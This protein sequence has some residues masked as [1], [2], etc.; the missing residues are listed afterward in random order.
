MGARQSKRSVDIS[1]GATKA[2]KVAAG[3]PLENGTITTASADE[4][5]VVEANGGVE[6]TTK[7][8]GSTPHIDEKE[9]AETE[10]VKETVTTEEEKTEVVAL[11]SEANG[12]VDTANESSKT[13][14]DETTT[15]E[16]QASAEK[17]KKKKKSWSFR[18]MSFNK[19]DKSK[20]TVKEQA[21][22]DVKAE[23]VEEVRCKQ[24]KNFKI[25]YK[26]NDNGTFNNY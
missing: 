18:H 15:E 10:D 2:E 3:E 8:N 5:Q 21:A 16:V 13:P 14:T 24:V 11:V 6:E 12:D 22:V 19:K 9:T 26:L 23:T 17:K 25:K 20:P 7:Q 4:K 1:A